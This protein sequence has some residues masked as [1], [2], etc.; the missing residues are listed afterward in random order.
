MATGSDPCEVPLGVR[1]RNRK[2]HNI[3]PSEAF[4]RKRRYETSPVV[5]VIPLVLSMTSASIID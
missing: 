1:M 3:R 4:D 5:T 2:L